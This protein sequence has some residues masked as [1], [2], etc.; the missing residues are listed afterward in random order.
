MAKNVASRTSLARF[1]FV[2]GLEVFDSASQPS[3][4]RKQIEA[5]ASCHFIEHGKN[6]VASARLG[7]QG[8]SDDRVMDAVEG[9]SNDPDTDA[10]PVVNS[11]KRR[12]VC[13]RI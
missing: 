3:L 10:T 6:I 2:K 11:R 13:A 7:R 4:D 12:L 5:L 8:S 9:Q 1:H